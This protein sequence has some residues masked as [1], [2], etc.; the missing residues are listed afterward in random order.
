MKKFIIG[1]LFI[2]LIFGLLCAC[3]KPPREEM[4]KAHDAVTRAENDAD[5]VMYASGTLVRARDALTRMQNE[6]DA[7]RYDAA[8]TYAAEA[9]TQAERAIFEGRSGASRAKDEASTLIS[10][11]VGPLAETGS[12]LDAAWRTE[13]LQIDFASLTSDM[14]AARR[15]FNDAQ[16]SLQSSRYRD[17]ISQG[18]TV[19]SLLSGIN[20]ALTESVIAVS[21]K[22]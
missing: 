5:T 2:I 10:S 11:L 14:E 12:A 20:A 16:L 17:A 13:K 15:N 21:R 6:A 22:K 7:K 3:A 9:I 8:K 1:L 18:Q 19:R 4:E